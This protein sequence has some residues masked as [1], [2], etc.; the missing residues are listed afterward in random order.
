MPP[1]DRRKPALVTED[2]RTR[3][4]RALAPLGF[5]RPR[6]RFFQYYALHTEPFGR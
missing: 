4:A 1:V 2:F 3:I 6:P 5:E